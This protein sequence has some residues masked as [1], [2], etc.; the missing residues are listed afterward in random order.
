M[1]LKLLHILSTIILIGLIFSCSRLGEKTDTK[2]EAPD[3]YRFKKVVL[4]EN[5][6]DPFELDIAPDG[7][8]FFIEKSG[9]LKAYSPVSKEV[10]TVTTLPVF[11][12]L[13]DGLIGLALAPNFE[14]T[15]WIYLLYSPAGNDPMQQLSRFTIKNDSLV[16][17]CEKKLLQIPVDR[18]HCC[19]SA[20]SLTFDAKGN[21]Y[22]STGDNSGSVNAARLYGPVDERKGQEANDAQRTSANTKDLRGKILRIHP[23]PNG[24]YTIPEGN[25]FPHNGSQGRP[26]IYVMG[27][28]N[29]FRMEVDRKTNYL[30]WG[31][32]GA[33]ADKDSP[34]GPKGY[35]ELNQ[36]KKAGNYGWPYFAADN[37]AYAKVDFAT[38]EAGARFNSDSVVNLSPNNTGISTLPP[39]Q[40]PLIW[41][42]YDQSEEFPDFGTGGRTIIAGPVYHFD[43][44]LQSDIKFPAYF[45]RTL[46]IAE[47]MRNWIKAVKL[48][49][50]NTI[51]HIEPFMPSAD[52]KKPIDMKFG[53]DGALYMIEF[54]SSWFANSDTKLVKI[55]YIPGNRPPVAKLVADKAFGGVPLPVT[56][57]AASSIDYDK[58][59]LSYQWVL[60]SSVISRNKEF[61]H[62]FEKP[63]KHTITLHV[64]DPEGKSASQTVEINAGNSMPQVRIELA[65]KTFYWDTLSYWVE[66]SDAEDGSLQQGGIE[67]A[68]VD[69]SV[70]YLPAAAKTHLQNPGLRGDLLIAESD[71]KACHLPEAQSVGPSFVSVANRYKSSEG[72]ISKLASKIIKG[73]SGVWGDRMMSPHPQLTEVQAVE[74]VKYILSLSTPIEPATKLPVSGKVVTGSP[75]K[76]DGVYQLKVV[77]SDKGGNSVGPLTVEVNQQLRSPNIEAKDF[78]KIYDLKRDTL[79]H[80]I[81]HNAYA[82]L[83]SIDLTGIQEISLRVKGYGRAE[84]RLGSPEGKL[85][86]TALFPDSSDWTVTQTKIEPTA[87]VQDIYFVFLNE[88][89]R[90]NF[91]TSLHWVYFSNG[92]SSKAK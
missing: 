4:A 33:D 40:K 20:G 26:E 7:R 67:A 8:V 77:Y 57:S 90:F 1:V 65:N 28:R 9:N 82:A 32:V 44:Q 39:A 52:F 49:P 16:R 10:K 61:T 23:E 13:D 22:V 5:L 81:P 18:D 17:S 56:F 2:A 35:D 25:L 48:S 73:G 72:V 68:K 54:G 42:P 69:V 84:I 46:F 74:M 86:G 70:A 36:T 24:T 34:K 79:L 15:N 75:K 62:T 21:L 85:I 91:S 38:G 78:D 14:Q 12:G 63:G 11:S 50:D 59:E 71:C 66:V 29:P 89:D 37:K 31:D 58:Q 47:W 87:G 60:N 55:E 43:P 41:Y 76:P 53:P 51:E 45:D 80:D 3:E 27:A 6:A 19:H 64:K 88:K 92:K 83:D 30:Y